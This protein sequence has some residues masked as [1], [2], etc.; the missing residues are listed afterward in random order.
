MCT[1]GV[2]TRL[3]GR[4]LSK[5]NA[6]FYPHGV[7]FL[8]FYFLDSLHGQSFITLTRSLKLY[9]NKLYYELIL[10]VF[11]SVIYLHGKQK[12]I[13]FKMFRSGIVTPN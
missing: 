1:C 9:I 3:R 2:T 4:Q 13:R 10:Y 7:C 12:D 8:L 11:T 5:E 6:N